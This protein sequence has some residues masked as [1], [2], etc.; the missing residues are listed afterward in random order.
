MILSLKTVA[1]TKQ[2]LPGVF[3]CFFL[4]PSY[5]Q[6]LPLISQGPLPEQIYQL[7]IE[8][9]IE[10]DLK[11]LSRVEKKARSGFE[12]GATFFLDYMLKS[13]N[14]VF[15]T[16]YNDYIDAVAAYLLKEHPELADRIHIYIL[17]SSDVNAFVFKDGVILIT[18]GLLAYIQNEAQLAYVIAHEVAH[19]IREHAWEFYLEG[20]KVLVN[21]SRQANI[22]Y[23]DEVLRMFRY[24]RENEFEADRIGY[25]EFF[26][27]SGYDQYELEALMLILHRSDLPYAN[28]PFDPAF[29]GEGLFDLEDS[30]IYAG[31][32][33]FDYRK[34]DKKREGDKENLMRTHPDM[35]KR[36]DEIRLFIDLKTDSCEPKSLFIVSEDRFR[37][38]QKAIRHEMSILYLQ[39]QRYEFALYQVWLNQETAAGCE[40]QAYA[41]AYA[42]YAITMDRFRTRPRTRST[43]E[44]PV[45]SG[46]I[47]KVYGCLDHLRQHPK[48]LASLAL[49]YLTDVYIQSGGRVGYQYY[50]ND[51][52]AIFKEEW[53]ADFF[54]LVT[55]DSDRSLLRRLNNILERDTLFSAVSHLPGEAA[56][57]E[58]LSTLAGSNKR[59]THHLTILQPR[60]LLATNGD[61]RLTRSE[62]G[63]L[64]AVR[65]M[66]SSMTGMGMNGELLDGMLFS[67]HDTEKF[68]RM[69]MASAWLDEYVNLNY[70]RNRTR[71]PYVRPVTGFYLTEMQTN[72]T[73]VNAIM[74]PFIYSN[75][76]IEYRPFRVV[77]LTIKYALLFPVSPLLMV[78]NYGFDD[79][80]TIL[81][82]VIIDTDNLQVLQESSDRIRHRYQ[83]HHATGIIHEYLFQYRKELGK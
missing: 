64:K 65:E 43:T 50:I 63:K 72:P 59:R 10:T 57:V 55:P 27:D 66:Q 1:K 25:E 11:G 12:M 35:E 21:A 3:L 17:R 48:L 60:F 29:F 73:A 32:T 2:I 44:E 4:L 67:R 22:N 68:N 70:A 20:F 51:L 38:M 82:S 13:G 30:V 71:T 36:I 75:H 81:G 40:K 6:N 83:H 62:Q 16:P 76:A 42:L 79:N 15:G 56:F 9:M 45:L 46:E 47:L 37:E 39:D 31:F 52:L 53:N 28:I 58:L 14:L 80:F 41:K 77:W 19:W 34:I 24:S 8:K 61:V 33:P 49:H 54:Q 23:Q 5:A 7:A 78:N 69:G 18:A 26:M 74:I